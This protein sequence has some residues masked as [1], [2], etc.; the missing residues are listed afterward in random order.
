MTVNMAD[1]AV[2]KSPAA[3]LTFGIGSCV[4]VC[5]YHHG[6]KLGGL[7]HI[8][9]PWNEKND[10][11]LT[12]KYADTAIP[13][14]IS[15]M[16]SNGASRTGI[17]AKII[18][19]ASVFLPEANPLEMVGSRNITAV[20]ET[21]SAHNIRIVAED[22]GGKHGRGISFDTETGAVEVTILSQPARRFL[23]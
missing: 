20:K 8:M 5:L 1:F 11:S 19:G 14:L 17:T 3:L 10:R 2:A 12:G 16:T 22:T 7:A 15:Q 18:G 9:L 23:L 6:T 21:L 13:A 4:A